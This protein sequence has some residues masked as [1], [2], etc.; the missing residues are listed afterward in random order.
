MMIVARHLHKQNKKDRSEGQTHGSDLD[1]AEAIPAQG[2]DEE[3]HAAPENTCQDDEPGAECF[4][5]FVH[6]DTSNDTGRIS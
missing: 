2:T 4:G 3:S 5:L 1:G 6:R